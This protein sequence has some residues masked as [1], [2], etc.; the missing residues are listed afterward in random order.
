MTC[1]ICMEP[2]LPP[3][4]Q[5]LNCCAGNHIFV[6][7]RLRV[8]ANAT[9][10]SAPG[11]A[12]PWSDPLFPE[13]ALGGAVVEMLEAHPKPPRTTPTRLYATTYS[14]RMPANMAQRQA[15]QRMAVQMEQM[16]QQQ[17]LLMA[18][19]RQSWRTDAAANARALCP[20]RRPRTGFQSYSCKMHRGLFEPAAGGGGRAQRS[21]EEHAG[22]P[23]P[24][25]QRE[26]NVERQLAHESNDDMDEATRQEILDMIGRGDAKRRH[27]AELLHF[28]RARRRARR[29]RLALGGEGRGITCAWDAYFRRFRAEHPDVCQP[30]DCAQCRGVSRALGARNYPERPEA[31]TTRPN[32]NVPKSGEGKLD[33][34]ANALCQGGAEPTFGDNLHVAMRPKRARTRDTWAQIGRM[35]EPMQPCVWVPYMHRP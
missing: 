3:E 22:S 32:P 18:H 33:Q 11:P 17:Q 4:R 27:S 15:M 30:R 24:V 6:A 13:V 26:R 19:M 9:T 5:P 8:T 25:Q 34:H 12:S 20:R 14:R 23:C 2:M 31:S 21:A 35:A 29:R 7:V 1:P 28:R 10:T 16:A